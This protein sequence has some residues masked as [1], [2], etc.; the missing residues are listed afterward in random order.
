MDNVRKLERCPKAIQSTV[1][2][3]C[4][5]PRAELKK[6]KE[7]AERRIVASLRPTTTAVP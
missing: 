6:M 2:G 4:N 3:T 5:A 7:E 1:P